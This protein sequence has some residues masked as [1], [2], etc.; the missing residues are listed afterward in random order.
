M[1]SFLHSV[2]SVSVV[3]LLTLTGYMCAEKG[4]AGAESKAFL[5]KFIMT[6]ALPC[7]CIYGLSTRLTREMLADYGNYLFVPICCIS[8]NYLLAFPLGKL[9]RFPRRSLGVFVVMCSMSNTMF[10]GYAMC[11]ELFGEYSV[12]Y[13]MLFYLVSTIFT[14]VV[15]LS[16]IRWSGETAS[17]EPRDVL[18]FL[19][20]PPILGVAI[21]VL[22]VIADLPLPALVLSYMG[23][24]NNLVAPLALILAGMI[25][26]EIG[27][28]N[29]KFNLCTIVLLIF[30]FFFAPASVIVAC[31]LFGIDGLARSVFVVEAAMPVVTITVVSAAEYNADEQLAAQGVA[32]STVACFLVIP[33][34]MLLL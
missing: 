33:V 21:G 14:Q 13:I 7:M 6:I 29:L 15:G 32:V 1:Q 8:L 28:N 34:I 11:Y 5:S 16:I 4:W 25:I 24:M 3:L 23:Y 9:L 17:S 10:I 18:K 2:S 31:K 12:P 19:A 26:H 27:L 30:R 20:S 22:L